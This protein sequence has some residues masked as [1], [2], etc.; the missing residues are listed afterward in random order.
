MIN[1]YKISY[2]NLLRKKIR[3]SLT[4]IGIA[5]SSFVLVSLLGFNAGYEKSLERDIAN[6]GFQYVLAAKGCPYEAATLMLTGSAGLKYIN[7]NIADDVMQNEEVDATTSMLM[8]AELDPNLGDHGA[9]TLYIGVDATTFPQMKPYLNFLQGDWFSQNDAFEAVLGYEAA[10]LEQRE[11]GDLILVPNRDITLKVVGI[12]NRSGTQDDGTIF[13]PLKTVQNIFDRENKLTGLGIRIKPNSDA[14]AFEDKLYELPDVQV[15]SMAQVRTTIMSLV[16]SAR[17]IVLS[18]AVIAV[19]IAMFGV[20]NTILMSVFERY[21]EIGIL[22]SMGAMPLDIFKMIWAETAILCSIGGLIGVMMSIG[23]AKITEILVR[24]FLPY[25]PYGNL[26]AIDL[27]TALFAF[28]V[29]TL[30][31]ILSGFYP[32][33]R[34]STV[35]PLDAIR[36]E[37]L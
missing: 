28:A 7:E 2:K 36:S 20:V 14:K 34:A 26:I 16:S 22:K 1:I 27:K 12:L 13:V 33:W 6:M 29:I 3:T 18:I 19:I 8:H 5:L 21:E 15:V 17:A 25:A 24:Q 4:I 30:A 32:A 10:E 35:R 31:G 37:M 23:L 9:M 11:V